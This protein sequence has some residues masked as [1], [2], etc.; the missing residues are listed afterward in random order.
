MQTRRKKINKDKKSY[1]II[2]KKQGHFSFILQRP[3][4]SQAF[5][6][7]VTFYL[8]SFEIWN[9]KSCFTLVLSQM[10]QPQSKGLRMPSTMELLYFTTGEYNN[11]IR[12]YQ[13][14][15]LRFAL[16]EITSKGRKEIKSRL[17]LFHVL[18]LQ[19]VIQR[20]ITN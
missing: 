3:V 2:H 4:I 19:R 14:H 17:I 1:L 9:I 13:L 7:A 5:L 18:I 15:N 20:E 16:N 6:T 8:P 11:Q 12:P 10:Q